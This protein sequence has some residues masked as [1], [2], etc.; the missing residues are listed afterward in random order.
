M[1]ALVVF[2]SMFGNTEEV[3]RS[4]KTDLAPE[5]TPAELAAKTRDRT[6]QRVARHMRQI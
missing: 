6:H 1:R 5:A 4:A 2:E 3:A